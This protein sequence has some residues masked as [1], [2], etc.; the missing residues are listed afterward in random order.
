MKV[1]IEHR[2]KVTVELP[3]YFVLEGWN[4]RVFMTFGEKSVVRVYNPGIDESLALYSQIETASIE[5]LSYL[6]DVKPIA[7]SEDQ[8]KHEF[9]KASLAIEALLN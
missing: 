9:I 5:Y 3:K 4:N 6:G 2:T 1:T 7:I 8:F